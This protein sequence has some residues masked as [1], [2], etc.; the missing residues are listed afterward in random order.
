MGKMRNLGK[1]LRFGE[2]VK[3][4]REF[5]ADSKATLEKIPKA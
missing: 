3:M 5:W 4:L 1:K 2:T